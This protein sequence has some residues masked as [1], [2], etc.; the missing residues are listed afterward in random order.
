MKYIGA[1]VLTAGL[2]S[3]VSINP[4]VQTSVEAAPSVV[5]GGQNVNIG[6][7]NSNGANSLAN[8]FNG[9]AINGSQLNSAD[10]NFDPAN[11]N[12]GDSLG[13][14]LNLGQIDFSD[15]NSIGSAILSMM[16]LLCAG[17]LFSLDNI[18]NLGQNNELELFL[19]LL[20]LMQLE[21]LG[22]LNQFQVLSLISSGF[23][24]SN[25]NIQNDQL[26]NIGM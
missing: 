14:G 21:Q 15:P 11:L 2:V 16:N 5:E 20:Q 24:N 19:Q 1:I 3:A 8:I 4:S 13:S 23:G 10:P 25:Q 7:P 22:F 26:F 17:N 6:D 12:L 9:T 18:L